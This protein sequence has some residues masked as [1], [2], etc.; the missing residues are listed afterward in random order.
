MDASENETTRMISF[1]NGKWY[2]VRLRVVPDRIQAW[3]ND[4]AL[5]DVDVTDVKHVPKKEIPNLIIELEAKMQAAA[6]A[7]DF[8]RAITLRDTIRTLER[9]V[10]KVGG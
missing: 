6:E 4:E 3:L 7:L 9:R 5:V 1:E 8:E 2:R 10:G